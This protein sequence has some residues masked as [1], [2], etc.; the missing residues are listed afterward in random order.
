LLSL[1]APAS[2]PKSGNK[3][4]LQRDVLSR[5]DLLDVCDEPAIGQ[6]TECVEHHARTAA[7]NFLG[8]FGAGA[9]HVVGN[10]YLQSKN[11]YRD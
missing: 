9:G 6:F 8:C 4:E 1:I 2:S 5:G 7:E 11:R 10:T 3:I